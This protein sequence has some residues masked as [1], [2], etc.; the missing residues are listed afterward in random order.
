MAGRASFVANDNAR[1]LLF[2]NTKGGGFEETGI[3]AG[4]AYNGDGRSISG[5]GADFGDI[6]GHGRYDIVMTALKNES[7][8]IFLNRGHGEF[9]DGSVQTGLMSMTHAVSGWGC[10]LVDLDNDGWLD[11]FVAGGGVD[12]ND[13]MTNKIYR[14]LGDKF[15]DVSVESGVGRGPARLHRG[16]IFAD[17]DHDGR[18]GCGCDVN[19]WA[20]RVVVESKPDAALASV[21]VNRHAQQTVRRSAPRSL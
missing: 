20:D 13:G 4:V 16:C 5:M 3:D 8:G 21:E 19:G 18:A 2:R 14:N 12:T 10:G 15:A 7:F 9:E 11:F 17:F 6:S 1:N